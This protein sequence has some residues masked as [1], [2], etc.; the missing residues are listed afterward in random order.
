M[1]GSERGEL[2]RLGHDVR[3]ALNGVAVNLEVARSRAAR[4]VESSQLT[5][6][7][8]AAAQQLEAAARLHKQYSDLII[9][10]DLADPARPG[11]VA[12]HR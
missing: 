2:K 3:N 1:R 7:L 6:F 8:E 11:E 4:G 12:D 9:A 10:L 5:P